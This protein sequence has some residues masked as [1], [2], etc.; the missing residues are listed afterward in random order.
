MKV[1]VVGA[2]V[3]KNVGYPLGVEL[4]D[5]IDAYIKSRRP[6]FNRFDYNKDWDELC[7]WLKTN[8]NPIVREAFRTKQLE[9]LF[10]ALD[11]ARHLNLSNLSEIFSASKKG[12][13]A[14]ANS[15]KSYKAF[16]EAIKSYQK[17]R[18]I[19]L[20][21]LEACLGFMHDSD[22]KNS[23]DSSWDSLWAF[24]RKLNPGDYIISFNYD[25]TL[26]R[27]LL[28]QNMWSLSNG[29]GFELVFQRSGHDKTLVPFTKSPVTI[30]HLHG[31]VGWYSKPALRADYLLT[32]FGDGSIPQEALTPAPKETKVA[33]DPQALSAMR[34]YAVDAC[35]P[36]A[37]PDEAQMLLYPTFIKD[38]EMMDATSSP[39]IG[40]WKQAANVLRTAEKAIII[41]Y[42]LPQAD[43]AAL[44]LLLTNCNR[45][46]TTIVNPS[47]EAHQRLNSMFVGTAGVLRPP[48][49]LRDWL[50]T[51][52]DRPEE[53]CVK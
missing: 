6:A 25:W 49:L 37:P 10:T 15:E 14:V 23:S 48:M 18:E 12:M 21:A 4:F 39:F 46:Q 50:K 34:I 1:Y 32:Q 26:E 20:W 17:Y 9:Y 35:L 29:F 19:L 13:D 3:S 24:G 40:L 47:P 7:T 16:N 31:A 5:A 11:L 38:Y 30:L 28:K 22:A 33:I 36:A 43:S 41:G 51:V 45:S 27:V 44:T 2:G 53:T 8:D 42:S 52:P